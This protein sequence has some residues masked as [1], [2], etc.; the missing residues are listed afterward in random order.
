MFVIGFGPFL[1]PLSE[2]FFYLI[3]HVKHGL[4]K[5]HFPVTKRSGI[6]KRN[7]RNLKYSNDKAQ[8]LSVEGEIGT[9]R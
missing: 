1:T 6:K 4:A 7:M 8:S 9:D 3:Q 5:A 2:G